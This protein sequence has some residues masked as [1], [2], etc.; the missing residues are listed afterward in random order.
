MPAPMR[1]HLLQRLWEILTEKDQTPEFATL[2]A[3]Q[4]Q[5]DSGDPPRDEAGAAG[6][7]AGILKER[8]T[9]RSH[10]RGLPDLSRRARWRY[11]RCS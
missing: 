3:E 8:K 1:E 7:L 6:L 10:A 5:A 4:R 2:T 11:V 9:G